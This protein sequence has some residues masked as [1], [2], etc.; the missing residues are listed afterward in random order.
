MRG[1][2]CFHSV[3]IGRSNVLLDGGYDKYIGTHVPV[4]RHHATFIVRFA[5]EESLF[6]TF[7]FAGFRSALVRFIL[8]N[9]KGW[10]EPYK[11]GR[12]L[13]IFRHPR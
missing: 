1:E 4:R 5:E 6:T 8:S 9:A 12:P 2:R 13:G 10:M 7:A 11:I 3:H